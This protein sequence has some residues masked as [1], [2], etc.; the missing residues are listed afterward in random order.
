M[1]TNLNWT[2][3]GFVRKLRPKQIHK[4]DSSTIFLK[5]VAQEV[6]IYPNIKPQRQTFLKLPMMGKKVC[7][8]FSSDSCNS[9]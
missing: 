4:I 3:L 8:V 7:C 1:F 6:L 2:K 5:M 9:I